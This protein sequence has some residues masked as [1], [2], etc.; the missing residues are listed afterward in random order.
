MT[1]ETFSKIV[2]NKP[3]GG[4]GSKS[5]L[6]EDVIDF[7]KRVYMALETNYES[8][9]ANS[10][11]HPTTGIFL[12]KNLFGYKDTSES[13]VT[14]VKDEEK[15]DLNDIRKRYSA[16]IDVEADGLEIVDDDDD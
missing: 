4:V 11:I 3:L 8:T 16:A 5:A 2:N 10:N 6:P 15:L 13:I 9:M 1:R 7:L 14:H 12:G